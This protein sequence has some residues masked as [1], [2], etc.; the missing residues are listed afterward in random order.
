M[1]E[2]EDFRTA[3][4]SRGAQRTLALG[5]LLG[6]CG[7]R[8]SAADAGA[9]GVCGDGVVDPGELC[10]DGNR[11][12]GD[13]CSPDC[14]RSG[15]AFDCVDLFEASKSVGMVRSILARPEAGFLV[16]GSIE[17]DVGDV[18][19]WIGRYDRSGA[20]QWREH[21]TFP[22]D[23]RVEIIDL[24]AD[25][26][27]G[28]WALVRSS[29]VNRLLHYDAQGAVVSTTVLAT[30]NGTKVSVYALE[31]TPAG[32][33]IVGAAGVADLETGLDAWVGIHDPE[34]GTMTD[35]LLEDHL[36]YHDWILAIGRND[37]EVAVSAR[38][39]TAKNF[40]ESNAPITAPSDTVVI[41][42][43][44]EGNEIG[45]TAMDASPDPVISRVAER[46]TSDASG[47]WFLSGLDLDLE[48]VEF[49]P[50]WVAPLQPEGGWSWTW[51]GSPSNHV[52]L[53][54]AVGLDVGVLAVGGRDRDPLV[55][56]EAWV[57]SLG[58]DGSLRWEFSN[59]QDDYYRFSHKVVMTDSEGRLRT[60]GEARTPGEPVL[61]RSCL[62]AY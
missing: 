19:G 53:N 31:S 9:D 49:L 16:A 62:I 17:H 24:A 46:V 33:W 21:L 30:A 15:M 44:L 28:A 54:D 11:V 43:D 59:E 7:P 35:I 5:L 50:Y 14:V 41:H 42:F 58:Q 34:T 29:S 26:S 22:N 13:G 40:S 55:T 36:G 8:G 32:V 60:A 39:S 48:G 38:L 4:G 2:S 61:A 1:L 57:A 6:A 51:T 3:A 47:Q 37:H 56:T 45:R 12:A 18:R 23:S 27:T 10:D 20:Q 25:D 52:W